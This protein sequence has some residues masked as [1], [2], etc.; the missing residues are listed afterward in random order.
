VLFFSGTG[1]ANTEAP[2]ETELRVH[3]RQEIDDHVE[4]C[5]R[6][7]EIWS[8]NRHNTSKR[9]STFGGTERPFDQSNRSE[10]A[11]KTNSII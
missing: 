4:H 5:P 8:L 3:H 1:C 2:T 7:L 11:L 10:P 9:A 6:S